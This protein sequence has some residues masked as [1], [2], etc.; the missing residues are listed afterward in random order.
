MV[1]VCNVGLVERMKYQSGLSHPARGNQGYIPSVLNLPDK[2]ICFFLPVT[3]IFIRN[4]PAD[5]ERI[6]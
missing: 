1:V 4:I 6:M 2:K 5:N 3:E